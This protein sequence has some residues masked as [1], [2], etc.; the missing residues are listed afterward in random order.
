MAKR[1]SGVFGFVTNSSSAIMHFP[2]EVLEHPSV[3][4]FM[5]A[6][7]LYGGFIG[8]HL[9]HRAQCETI[10][11]G[12]ERKQ[13]VLDRLHSDAYSYEDD[14]EYYGPSVDVESPGGL[15]IY[16][17]EYPGIASTLHGIISAAA[18]EMGL[19]ISSSEY[20]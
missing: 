6:Y 1:V 2:V 11:I 17:D 9:W 10:V 14:E 8:K 5:D 15:L 7:G 20:N 12:K 13:E 19:S 4:H 3:K 16:G 18:H